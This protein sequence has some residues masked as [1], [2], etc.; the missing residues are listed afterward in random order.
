MENGLTLVRADLASFGGYAARF[1]NS[2]Y[3]KSS[4]WSKNARR[5]KLTL[6]SLSIIQLLIN[7]AS[8]NQW[9]K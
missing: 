5:L 2:G 9:Q 8:P 6:G 3:N 7:A 1:A 4:V